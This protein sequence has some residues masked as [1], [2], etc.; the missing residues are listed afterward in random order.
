MWLNTVPKS[1]HVVICC[2]I[3]SSCGHTCP[4][5]SLCS[6]IQLQ[7]KLNICVKT[8]V[9]IGI[10]S[11][12]PLIFTIWLKITHIKER[13]WAICSRWS[14]K[15]SNCEQISFVSLYKRVIVS[16]SLRLLMTK[17]WQERFTL[18]H[19]RIAL[20]LFGSQKMSDLHKNPMSEFP[21]LVKTEPIREKVDSA[22][23]VW[24]LFQA[25]CICSIHPSQFWWNSSED[26][27]SLV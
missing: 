20:S 24:L 7:N 18:F 11:F 4:N 23:Y 3:I 14:L 5:I 19:E 21:I 22:I 26:F 1:P 8:R 27:P 2:P 6:H 13:L 10:R 12:S 15:K 25:C 17:E 9:R 16:D